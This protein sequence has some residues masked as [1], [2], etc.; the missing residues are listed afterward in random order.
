MPCH[1]SPLFKLAGLVQFG[2]IYL[3]GL[4][5]N[6]SNLGRWFGAIAF[7]LSQFAPSLYRRSNQLTIKNDRSL[8]AWLFIL[9]ADVFEMVWPFALKWSV[10]FSR[11]SPLAVAIVTSIP[12]MFL[13]AESVK[14]L[15][16]ATVYAAFVGIG[17]A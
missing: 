8:M 14:R 10:Q 17:V 6:E 5:P 7:A 13:L 1:S 2:T 9:I 4:I 11:W 12:M 15:P 16:A 3:P